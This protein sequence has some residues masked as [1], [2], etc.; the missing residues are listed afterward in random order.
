MCLQAFTGAPRGAGGCRRLH[1]SAATAA[2]SGCNQQQEQK[3]CERLTIITYTRIE[4]A[5]AY[6]LQAGATAGVKAPAVVC[7]VPHATA[8]GWRAPPSWQ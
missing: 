4:P 8:L 3:D 7:R 1:A 2:T 6:G 5:D